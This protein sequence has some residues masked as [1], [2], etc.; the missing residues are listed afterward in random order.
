MRNVGRGILERIASMIRGHAGQRRALNDVGESVV[1]DDGVGADIGRAPIEVLGLNV[2][3]TNCLR[4]ANVKRVR[5]L[6]RR[7]EDDLLR[8]PNLGEGTLEHICSVLREHGLELGR[9]AD[10]DGVS[11]VD[12]R[13]SV[14]LEASVNVLGLNVRA[15]N[16]LRRLGAGRVED[17]VG[18]READLLMVPNMGRGTVEHISAVLREYGLELDSMR[19]Q[20][21][22][23]DGD[24]AVV[25]GASGNSGEAREHPANW[26]QVVKELPVAE[27][28]WSV[29]EGRFGVGRRLT[30]RTLADSIG[31][32]RER[33][34]QIEK[35]GVGV[36]NM[37][38][39]RLRP[40]LRE[41][42]EF[43]G[44]RVAGSF[45]AD[46][47]HLVAEIRN[48]SNGVPLGE[49][50]HRLLVVLRALTG[51]GNAEGTWPIL[52]FRACMLSPAMEKH[53]EVRKRLDQ[54]EA[55]AR[56][57]T[58]QWTYRE[59]ALHV[60]R[61]EQGPLHWGEI[62]ERCEVL[63]KRKDFSASSCFNQM[64]IDKDLFVRVGQG[65]YALT[66]WGIGRSE[67]LNDL[68]ASLLFESSKCLS[69]GEILHRSSA[70]QDVKALSIQMT[71][72]LHPRFYRSL[73]GRYGLRAWL[74]T[75]DRQTLRT[76]KDLV[77]AEDS[78]RR[79]SN[80]LAKGYNVARMVS[81]DQ[82]R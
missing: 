76:P 16:C 82:G 60:L 49:D 52:S 35:A 67:T 63:G 4:R 37:Q 65:T 57:R 42:E 68:I 56:E 71:L 17:L 27:R 32:T 31:V 59:L 5:D 75:R 73:S 72:D 30:L 15:S 7:A 25:A 81:E 45:E 36:L 18:L 12:G 23:V 24:E 55:A 46:V 34:R 48:V 74:P 26:V 41:L 80:A 58:R 70:R 79:V 44:E 22:S 11:Q 51:A 6:V 47:D 29:L 39:K 20:S 21:G 77:E 54:A 66:E 8:V 19:G 2:R 13:E 28:T 50:V 14:G 53:S 1:I 43:L 61:E 78:G 38:V 3:A 10:G 33:V 40:G 62:A 64:Q 69:Y 9:E